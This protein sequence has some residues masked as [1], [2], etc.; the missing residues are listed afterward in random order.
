MKSDSIKNPLMSEH[1]ER[2]RKK[3]VLPP[4]ADREEWLARRACGIGGTDIG[5][6][7]HQSPWKSPLRCTWRRPERLSRLLEAH[8][9][10]RK[11]H[12]AVHSRGVHRQR[13]AN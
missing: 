6:I 13:R 9:A 3:Q 7:M 10:G 2:L 8:H 4:D 12:G 1:I 11:S 5:A